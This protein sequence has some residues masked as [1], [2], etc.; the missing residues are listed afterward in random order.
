MVWQGEFDELLAKA[1]SEIR[2]KFK[3]L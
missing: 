1:S 2:G 3:K